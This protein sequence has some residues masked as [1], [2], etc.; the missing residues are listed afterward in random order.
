M[1]SFA[2]MLSE[3]YFYPH[4]SHFLRWSHYNR[5]HFHQRYTRSFYIRKLSM[6][7]F[8]FVLKFLVCTLLVQ[9]CWRKSWHR[10]LMKLSPGVY[11]TNILRK[12]FCTKVQCADFC[13]WSLAL[14]FFGA[15]KLEQKML[16]K[17]WWNWLVSTFSC[18]IDFFSSFPYNKHAPFHRY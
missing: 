10:M 11:F 9:D 8:F 18:F 7:L 4:A 17:G 2:I 6:Q 13:T 3:D 5:C 1:K 14:Y 16:S 15:R 12:V